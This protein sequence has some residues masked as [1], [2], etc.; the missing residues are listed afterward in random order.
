MPSMRFLISTLMKM[1]A[2]AIGLLIAAWALDKMH[3][4]GWSFISVVVAFTIIDIIV[5][6]LVLSMTVKNGSALA[7]GVALVSTFVS[8]LICDIIFDALS[9]SGATTWIAAVV[10]TWLASVIAIVLLPFIL[11][12]FGIDT[13]KEKQAK[14]QAGRTF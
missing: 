14:A 12:K 10:I 2:N 13:R 1:A 7:G 5:S 4:D 9:I 3:I 6:P 8:L 11:V